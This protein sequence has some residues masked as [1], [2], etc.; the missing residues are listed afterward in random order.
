MMVISTSM[1]EAAGGCWSTKKTDVE[2]KARIVTGFVVRET[3]I[4]YE[5]SCGVEVCNNYDFEI[6]DEKDVLIATTN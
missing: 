6:S 5:L 1:V 4:V 2:Q 3:A